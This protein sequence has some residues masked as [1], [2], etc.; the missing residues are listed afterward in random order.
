MHTVKFPM[1]DCHTHL[2]K[3]EGLA[4]SKALYSQEKLFGHENYCTLSLEGFGAG[5]QDQNALVMA[6]KREYP[7]TYAFGGINHAMGNIRKQAESL[8]EMGCDGFKMIEGKPDAW[9]HV[10]IPLDDSYYCDLYSF[11][12]EKGAPLLIHIADPEVFW[13]IDNIPKS[14]YDMGWYYDRTFQTKEAL[15]TQAISIM[16][17]FPD[18]KI[19]FAHFFYLAEHLPRMGEL[20]DRFPNMYTDITPGAPLYSEM[21][22]TYDDSVEF[23]K[24]YNT[25]ILYGSDTSDFHN[26]GGIN[27]ISSTV[28]IIRRFVDTDDEME[29]WELYKFKGLNLPDEV[30]ANIFRDNFL[31]I[32]KHRDVNPE[33]AAAYFR[34]MLNN[35]DLK[36]SE[37]EY[38]NITLLWC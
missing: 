35:K 9:S 5:M 8:W 19:I 7:N 23:F 12:V 21:T 38:N 13:D 29:A 14:D 22:A 26:E 11:C 15:T 24:K 18:M 20:F 1:I 10:N 27:Y 34:D 16:E 36:L 28:D 3:H 30:K 25:R 17:K 37:T 2:R 33:K 31:R 32:V 4:A 6:N